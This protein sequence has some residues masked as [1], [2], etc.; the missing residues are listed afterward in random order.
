MP[1]L[2]RCQ[3]GPLPDDL[4]SDIQMGNPMTM[5][6]NTDRGGHRIRGQS[7]GLDWMRAHVNEPDGPCLIWPFAR[8]RGYAHMRVTGLTSKACRIMCEMVNGPAPSPKHEAAHSCGLGKDGC[9]HPKHLSWKTRSENQRER[10]K[11]GTHGK[12]PNMRA[13]GLSYKLNP[14]KVAEI[15]SIGDSMSKEAIGRLFGITPSNVAKILNGKAWKTGDWPHHG[16]QPGDPR[17]PSIK[18]RLA[19]SR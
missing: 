14:K 5:T 4:A 18:R 2:P 6:Q 16:W 3:M 17:N 8:A 12:G 13:R 7:K 19:L 15:R 9:I 10:R 11:H 1:S